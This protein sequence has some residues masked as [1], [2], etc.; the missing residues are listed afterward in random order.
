MALERK[1]HEKGYSDGQI[2]Q[3]VQYHRNL[4]RY[5]S[6]VL[7]LSRYRSCTMDS[8]S[9]KTCVTSVQSGGASDQLT[10]SLRDSAITIKISL[11]VMKMNWYES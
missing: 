7:L 10:D 1:C 6:E 11:A 4:L 3:C 2:I 9:G 8:V 5:V